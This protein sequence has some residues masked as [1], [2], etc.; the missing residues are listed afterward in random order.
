MS[1]LIAPRT[2]VAGTWKRRGPLTEEQK[3]LVEEAWN[4][5]ARLLARFQAIYPRYRD[6]IASLFGQI[7]IRY[8]PSYDPLR[9]SVRRWSCAMLKYALG[10]ALRLDPHTESSSRL[11]AINLSAFRGAGGEEYEPAEL[12]ISDAESASLARRDVE[13]MLSVLSERD[14]RIVMDHFRGK[15]LQQIGRD[16]FLSHEGVR[17]A[18]QGAMRRLRNRFNI[19]GSVL[20]HRRE[21]TIQ[22]AMEASR[23]QR[24]SDNLDAWILDADELLDF[25]TEEESSFYNLRR[26]GLSLRQIGEDLGWNEARV[27]RTWLAIK[28][29]AVHCCL[30]DASS[31]DDRPE[32]MESEAE[33]SPLRRFIKTG[34]RP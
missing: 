7:L 27:N 34:Q 28:R 13:A 12:G 11:R 31:G 8:V 3:A 2:R 6:S 24:R 17:L 20:A 18:L 23:P 32:S 26:E 29:R 25:L 14:A 19:D 4:Y 33:L 21:E 15:T 30:E 1:I 5:Q 22:Q 9:C 16:V 10:R